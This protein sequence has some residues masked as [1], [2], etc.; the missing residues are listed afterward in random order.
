MRPRSLSRSLSLPRAGLVA[1]L[2]VS[3]AS[4][5]ACTLPSP[6]P[7]SHPGLPAG[8]T[9]ATMS[10]GGHVRS[11]RLYVPAAVAAHPEIV[12]PVVIGLHGG[13]GSG[14]QFV[15]TAAFD[16]AAERGQ[17]ISVAPD[18]LLLASYPGG[19]MV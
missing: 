10:F 16:A 15:T 3:M 5:V 14:S 4:A 6:P 2:A 8:V 9:N 18:G 7:A 11:Y 17:F 19:P 12:A 1:A 13:L